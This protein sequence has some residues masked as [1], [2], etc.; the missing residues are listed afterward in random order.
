VKVRM[1]KGPNSQSAAPAPAAPDDP[2][3]PA[4]HR[5][6]GRPSS[7]DPERFKRF[8]DALRGGNSIPTAAEYAGIDVATMY[9]WL[10]DP[11][12]QYTAIRD[13]VEQAK[14]TAR[15]YV[16]SNLVT[17]SKRSPRAAEIWLKV[18]GG[19]EWRSKCQNCGAEQG[20][21]DA[22]D[23]L[24]RSS[25]D[26][27]TR[28]AALSAASQPPA[29]RE[30]P[31]KSEDPSSQLYA[32]FFDPSK[33]VPEYDELTKDWRWPIG[34]MLAAAAA[35]TTPAQF[36]KRTRGVGPGLREDAEPP[37]EWWELPL[38]PGDDADSPPGNAP[39]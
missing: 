24:R 32:G 19:P 18:H 39:L 6:R 27:I 7:Y 33:T 8:L 5:R 2:S 20:H 30:V 26:A 31:S 34:R 16:V 35:G 4:E 13:R 22:H 28:Q 37:R 23:N 9:R 12:P 29:Q 11:R 25:P 10:K 36:F 38:D 3:G 21:H 1:A 14:A 15:V 17:L